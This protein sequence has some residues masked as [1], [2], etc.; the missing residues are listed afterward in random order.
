MCVCE[1][2]YGCVPE[3][4]ECERLCS[5]SLLCSTEMSTCMP[6]LETVNKDAQ[7]LESPGQGSPP[8]TNNNCHIFDGV[9]SFKPLHDWFHG[10]GKLTDQLRSVMSHDGS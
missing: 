4:T 2:V 3:C 9:V 7:M 8:I 5:S 1:C 10:T 6:A